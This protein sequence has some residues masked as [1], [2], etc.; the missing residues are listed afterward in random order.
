MTTRIPRPLALPDHW[1]PAQALA[2]FELIEQ[3]RDQLWH[4]Y[5]PDIQRATRDDRLSNETVPPQTDPPF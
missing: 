1:T 3:L 5:R 2:V 4:A